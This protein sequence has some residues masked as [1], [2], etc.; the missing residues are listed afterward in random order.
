MKRTERHLPEAIALRVNGIAMQLEHRARSLARSKHEA[1][2]AELAQS[3]DRG[4]LNVEDAYN[5]LRREI[6][7][8]VPDGGERRWLLRSL[9]ES[10]QRSYRRHRALLSHVPGARTVSRRRIDVEALVAQVSALV[11]QH[12]FTEHG[13]AAAIVDHLAQQLSFSKDVD[14]LS[15][16]EVTDRFTIKVIPR[17]EVVQAIGDL[18]TE[19][20]CEALRRRLLMAY[21][22]CPERAE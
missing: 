3:R 22:R 20:G 19:A 14:V 9:G 2:A 7:R 21:R 13:A 1:H 16:G 5:K 11:K 4:H 10:W 15:D 8:V 12:G 17:P 6:E 18:T